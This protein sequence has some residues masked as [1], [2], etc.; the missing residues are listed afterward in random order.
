[1]GAPRAIARGRGCLC[2]VDVLRD[3]HGYAP[4]QLLQKFRRQR[5]HELTHRSMP[6]QMAS[7]IR[8]A[9]IH[10]CLPQ[11]ATRAGTLAAIRNMP[12]SRQA[13]TVPMLL[14]LVVACGV[15]VVPAD[16]PEGYHW[17]GDPIR[18]G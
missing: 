14:P 2:P 11:S 15:P 4:L 13:N 8:P 6:T 12:V 16:P 17:R 7:A 1:M 9:P 5:F 10:R 3:L 18:P